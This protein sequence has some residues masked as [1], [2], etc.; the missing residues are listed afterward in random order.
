ML[1]Y[2]KHQSI[3]ESCCTSSGYCKR[4]WACPAAQALSWIVLLPGTVYRTEVCCPVL[5][6]SFCLILHTV[7]K[8]RCWSQKTLKIV[9]HSAKLEVRRGEGKSRP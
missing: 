7:P 8:F 3:K 2:A 4:Y 9:E 1:S 6:R 5:D